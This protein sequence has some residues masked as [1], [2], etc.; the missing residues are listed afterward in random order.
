MKQSSRPQP[1]DAVKF[2]KP[3]VL[4]LTLAIT[5]IVVGVVRD[6]LLALFLAAVFSSLLLPLHSGLTARLAGR[7]RTSAALTLL[8]VTLLIVVP[9]LTMLGVVVAQGSH[10]IETAIPWLRE[11][12]TSGNSDLINL[13]QWFPFHDRI[14]LSAERVAAKLGE[15]TGKAGTFLLS[16]LSAATQGT[17]TFLV[18]L[19]V[20][21]YAMFYFLCEGPAVRRTI[22]RYL[23]LPDDVEQSLEQKSVSVVRATIKGTF[24]IG[25][26][27]GL[28][29][30]VAF[31]VLGID[32]AA[33]WA[34]LMAV[35]SVV[36]VV[37]TALVWGPAVVFLSITGQGTAAAGLLA[38][39]IVV[40]GSVD[41]LLRPR[42][43]GG[44][45]QMPDLVIL[46]STLGG[47]SV[48][49]AAGIMIGPLLAAMC[50]TMWDILDNEL[51]PD[52]AAQP[53]GSTETSPEND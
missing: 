34:S 18:N 40:I 4:L 37:G 12:L 16:G 42:L 13:P 11:H 10:V 32:G 36:P 24:V 1:E 47:L 51:H 14:D 50:V 44:D 3:L 48:F 19:F 8:V 30:G 43:V 7:E 21:L 17:A 27:Q 46:V 38:W 6:F 52:V 26:V 49:G 9:L 22:V 35:S 2:R 29:G 53:S 15:L 39:S 20:M 23:P 33:F 5:A 31:A 28:L 45:T 25:L 41:N